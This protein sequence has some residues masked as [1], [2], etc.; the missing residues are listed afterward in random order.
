LRIPRGYALSR[1]VFDAALVQ[2]AIKS[3]T[4]FRQGV[5]ATLEQAQSGTVRLALSDGQIQVQCHALVVVVADGIGGRTLASHAEFD[6]QMQAGSK[7]GAG[8]ILSGQENLIDEGTI[9]MAGANHGYVGMV[10]LP[11]DQIDVAAALCTSFSRACGGPGKAAEKILRSCHMPVPDNL[12][13]ASW[14]GTDLLTR[15]RKKIAGQRT[16]VIGDASGYAEPLTGEGISWA[17]WSALLASP[18]VIAAIDDWSMELAASWQSIHHHLISKRQSKSKFIASLFG[19]QLLRTA[20]IG[21]LRLMPSLAQPILRNFRHETMLSALQQLNDTSTGR[22]R[23]RRA[24]EE[25]CPQ[26]F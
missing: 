19:H 4:Q 16:F 22:V 1:G 20:V 18:L 25:P 17:L 21:G 24:S 14:H 11:G 15:R 13:G 23:R 26:V 12:A 9:Y 6:F 10:R 3:G 8:V 2:E 7:F 5:S